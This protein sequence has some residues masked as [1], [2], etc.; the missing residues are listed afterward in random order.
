[1]IS[2]LLKDVRPGI[3][4]DIGSNDPVIESNTFLLYLHGWKGICVDLNDTLIKKAKLIRKRDINIVAAV[5]DSA[6]EIEMFKFADDCFS[7]IDAN[8]ARR[9]ELASSVV[10]K[11]SL[12]TTTIDR[13]LSKVPEEF[14]HVDLLSIDVEGVD[15]KVLKSIDYRIIRPK[16]II[17]EDWD[18][19]YS[20]LSENEIVRFLREK[21][22]VFYSYFAL[23]LIF[24]ESGFL[25][26]SKHL[27]RFYK[28]TYENN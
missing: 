20:T 14:K 10:S 6:T 23:N 9:S 26:T 27:Q 21:G 8:A 17:I 16:V 1:M 18:F 25:R 2:V 3:Y 22:Y 4:L 12:T 13:I 19:A 11:T 24:L 7:T 5:S 28:A 15:V